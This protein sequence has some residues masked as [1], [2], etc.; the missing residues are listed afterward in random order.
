[1]TYPSTDAHDWRYY[2]THWWY[3]FKGPAK[4]KQGNDNL[5]PGPGLQLAKVEWK[6]AH[7]TGDTVTRERARRRL[8]W[9]RS[10]S[11]SNLWLGANRSIEADVPNG[12]V[13]WRDATQYQNKAQDWERFVDTSAYF[14]EVVLMLEYGVDTKYVPD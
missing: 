2:G 8:E 9:A 10:P 11:Y 6:Y 1:M 5:Y 3:V 14:I 4:N 7:A 13:D 12:L